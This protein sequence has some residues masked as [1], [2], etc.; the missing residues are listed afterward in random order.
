MCIADNNE[1]TQKKERKRKKI[2][3]ASKEIESEEEN[4][5]DR[6]KIMHQ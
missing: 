3:K 1:G 4:M 2:R 5:S 6:G